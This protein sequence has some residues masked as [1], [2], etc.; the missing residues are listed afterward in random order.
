M[1][2][3]GVTIAKSRGIKTKDCK[4][5]IGKSDKPSKENGTR[6]LC[7]YHHSNSHSNENC[8]QQEQ[9]S[10]KTRCTYHKSARHSVDQCYHQRSK[11][12]TYETSVADSNV[13]GCD[14]CSCN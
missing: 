2:L 5:L 1:T 9:Q 10:G 3:A 11:S 13:N 4:E 6:K 12:T 7:S 14:K 8:Y